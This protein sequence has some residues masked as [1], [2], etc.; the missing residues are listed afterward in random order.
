MLRWNRKAIM[1]KI[2]TTYGTDAVPVAATNAILARNVRV[3]PLVMGYERREVVRPF[4]SNG[5]SI[6]TGQWSTISMEIE[7]AGRGAAVDVPPS[8]GVLLRAAG[9]AET[10]N[11]ATSVQYDPVSN[12]FEAATIYFYVD[13]KLNKMVGC[14]ASRFGFTLRAGAVP[15][16]SFDFMGLHVNIWG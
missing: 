6:I 8:Y 14:R 10:V 11:A 2:E 9:N 16:F 7:M 4:Y 13:G 3:V 12:A 15:Y 1:A 5:G